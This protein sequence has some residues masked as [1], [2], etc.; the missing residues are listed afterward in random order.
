MKKTT[1]GELG[2]QLPI[3]QLVGNKFEKEFV[4]K[5][6]KAKIDRLIGLWKQTQMKTYNSNDAQLG[7]KIVPKFLS[8]ICERVGTKTM[9]VTDKGDST[10]EAELWV[11]KWPMSD[12]LY[13]YIYTRVVA[14]DP[15]LKVPAACGTM[16]CDFKAN[17]AEFDLRTLEVR[18]SE[19]INDTFEWVKL[20]TPIKNRDGSLTIR[21]VRVEPVSWLTV[22]NRGAPSSVS[23]PFSTFALRESIKAI[24]KGESKDGTSYTLIEDEMDELSKRDLIKLDQVCGDLSLGIDI[25]TKIDC[26]KCGTPMLNLLDWDFES[27]FDLSFRLEN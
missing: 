15:M 22:V 1:L 20:T 21:E 13:M 4:L 11:S 27:F 5:P 3:G 7:A 16:G 23:S 24:N 19:T 2:P 26:P 9:P 14:L 17:S 12:V 25:T 18:Y 8:L 10:A 6:Y